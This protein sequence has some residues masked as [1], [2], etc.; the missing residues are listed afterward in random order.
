MFLLNFLLPAIVLFKFK[1]TIVTFGLLPF[2]AV[3]FALVKE[4]FRTKRLPNRILYPATLATIFIMVVVALVRGDFSLFLQPFLRG[5]ISFFIALL[6]YLVAKGGFGAGDIKLFFLTGLALGIFSTAHVIAGAVFA[7][8]GVAAYAI[9]L[10][11]TK[12]ASAKNTVP[13]GPFIIGG[14][15][16]AIFLFN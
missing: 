2:A 6:I 5:A 3:S 8:I 4:D 7:C 11:L 1:L 16:L 10:M 15:W 12:R 13:F 14:S 9:F